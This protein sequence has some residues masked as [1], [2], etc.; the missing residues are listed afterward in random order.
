MKIENN[1]SIIQVYGS[2]N[3]KIQP[4]IVRIYITIRHI[5]KTINEAQNEVNKRVKL[6][7]NL[8]N[9][10]NIENINTNSL[11]F[12]P[13]YEWKNN[14][15]V[16]I[17]QKVQQNIVITIVDIKNNM[18]KVTDLLDK[19]T[20]EIEITNCNVN[21]GIDNYEEK[22]TEARNLAYNNA[23]EKA[24]NYA[25]QA[26]LEIIKNIKISEFEPKNDDD[27]ED[28][29]VNKCVVIG[30]AGNSSTELPVSGIVI[31]SKLFCDFIAH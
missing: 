14:K 27:Y 22:L 9:E 23:L 6:L 11:D 30:G 20:M 10:L 2:G 12:N 19:I 3:I 31:K 24:K 17:G 1:T 26:N 5:S 29:Y 25:K 13:E 28:D 8:V 15:N 21:F 18:Q 7:L 4:N 16:L